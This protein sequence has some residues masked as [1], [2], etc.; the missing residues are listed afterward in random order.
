MYNTFWF[1]FLK[2][3]LVFQKNHLDLILNFLRFWL[4][5]NFIRCSTATLR[6]AKN[7]HRIAELT[8]VFYPKKNNR[9]D[10]VRPTTNGLLT[11]IGISVFWFFCNDITSLTDCWRRTVARCWLVQWLDGFGM[12]A[13]EAFLPSD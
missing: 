2:K 7:Y 8:D 1:H 6:F 12:T 5:E 4:S 3:L 10:A 9:P 13:N 11:R